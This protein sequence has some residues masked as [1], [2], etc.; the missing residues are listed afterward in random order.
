M[1]KSLQRSIKGTLGAVSG[2][3]VYTSAWQ[4]IDSFQSYMI[5]IVWTGTPT[6]TVVLLVS[7]DPVPAL[8]TFRPITVAA[9]TNYDVAANSSTT[10]AGKTILTYDCIATAANWVGVQWTNAS[11]TGTIQSVNLV[12]K[13]SQV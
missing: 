7:A 5:Q 3:T 11:G 6:A 2:T 8:E 9:P 12:A 10:T 13:G 1:R 4:P